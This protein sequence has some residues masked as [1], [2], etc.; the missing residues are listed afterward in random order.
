[1]LGQTQGAS[2]AYSFVESGDHS[3]F[4]SQSLALIPFLLNIL[5]ERGTEEQ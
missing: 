5:G 1:M 4:I 3:Y 2:K